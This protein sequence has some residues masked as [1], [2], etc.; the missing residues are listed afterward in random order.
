MASKLYKYFTC[1]FLTVQVAIGSPVASAQCPSS[2]DVP[3]SP[4]PNYS[5]EPKLGAVASESDICSRIGTDLLRSGGNVADATVG[6]VICVSV[7]GMYHSGKDIL[8]DGIIYM[9]YMGLY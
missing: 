7:I 5:V 4:L 3:S 1:L 8:A 9:L 2:S 6:T